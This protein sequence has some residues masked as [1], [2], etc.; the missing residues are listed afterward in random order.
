MTV[1]RFAP[2]LGEDAA[3]IAARQFAR[4]GVVRLTG[5][6]SETDARTLYE[7]VARHAEWWRVVNQGEKVWDLGPE[8]IA[9]MD[10]A[11]EEQLR[12][13]VYAGARDGFQF[14]Y[15]AVRVPE[16]GGERA[17]RKSPLDRLL[18]AL[19]SPLWLGLLRRVTGEPAIEF[20]DGQATR[21][22]PG[23]FL[24]A[25]DDGVEGK[26]RLVAYVLGVT[27]RWRTEWGGLLQFHEENG[28]V[29]RA[30]LPSFNALHLFRV[31]QV[32]SVSP[33]SP[34]AGAPRYSVTGWLRRRS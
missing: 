23:H 14:F 28:D 34:F 32:H 24:T 16:D 7:Y 15:D 29:S 22:L 6:L 1:P 13:L 8:S 11:G 2:A 26:N 4:D 33:V 12:Q 5:V 3:D 21:Y 18:D 25:H 19:N 31:P 17:L 9:Q 27:P 30:L 10:A 20:V